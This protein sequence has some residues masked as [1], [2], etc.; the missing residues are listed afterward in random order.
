MEYVVVSEVTL[1]Q[2]LGALVFQ[3]F[4]KSTKSSSSKTSLLKM[5]RLFEFQVVDVE[6]CVLSVQS[7]LTFSPSSRGRGT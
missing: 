3:A 6:G 1:D 2:T 7:S 4:P 5:K